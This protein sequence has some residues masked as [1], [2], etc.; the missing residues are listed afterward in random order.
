MRLVHSAWLTKASQ[1]TTSTYEYSKIS[2]RQ[3]QH[4]VT[5]LI[6]G[7]AA[8]DLLEL[9]LNKVY[10]FLEIFKCCGISNYTLINDTL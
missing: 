2:Y 7:I 9:R 5:C 8:S 10:L 6:R 1:G 4:R 3:D